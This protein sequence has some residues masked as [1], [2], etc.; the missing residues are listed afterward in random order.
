VAKIALYGHPFSS[1]TWKALIA[2]HAADL[3]YALKVLS[4]EAPGNSAFV[5]ERGGPAG[6]F[7]VLDDGGRVLFES[8]AIIEY[9]ALVY[10]SARGLIPIDAD[11]AL[12]TRM[13]DRVFDNNVMTPVQRIVSEYLRPGHAPDLV[14]ADEQRAKLAQSYTWLERW[15]AGYT[16]PVSPTLVE[17]AAAPSLFYADWVAPISEAC[18]RLRAFR[19]ELLARPEVSRCVEAARPYRSLFPPGAPDRD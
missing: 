11:A 10:P 12:A 15:L 3:D 13:I 6:Q 8:T 5:R 7:P 19:T 4:P 2:L 1:Y 17:C 9:L 16:R 14:R 18:P